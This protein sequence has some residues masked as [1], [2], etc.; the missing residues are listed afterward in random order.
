M[1]STATD[2]RRVNRDA[3]QALVC[4]H[5]DATYMRHILTV[6]GE[7]VSTT[8]RYWCLWCS[9]VF[10]EEVECSTCKD[11]ATEVYYHSYGIPEPLCEPH[12]ER[13][14]ELRRFVDSL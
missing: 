8:V 12:Y 1:V 9:T 11:P 2:R 7:E 4:D 14:K 10:K 3:L 5:E 13:A 6:D